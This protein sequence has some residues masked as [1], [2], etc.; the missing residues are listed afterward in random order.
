MPRKDSLAYV[1]K[2]DNRYA[3]AYAIYLLNRV[4]RCEDIERLKEHK[5][6]ITPDCMLY[7]NFAVGKSMRKFIVHLILEHMPMK[8]S[9][10]IRKMN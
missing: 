2:S 8:F 7:Q 6:A 9:L 4:I 10:K 3:K 1:V 5:V